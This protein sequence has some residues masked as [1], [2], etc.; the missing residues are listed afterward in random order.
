MAKTP[1]FISLS[2]AQLDIFESI[3]TALGSTNLLLKEQHATVSS[4]ARLGGMKD[5][6]IKKIRQIWE[7]EMS[8]LGGSIGS[9]LGGARADAD[10]TG[11]YI[12][13]Q[14]AGASKSVQ[15]LLGDLKK[16][17]V[18][19]VEFAD[20]V[21]KAAQETEFVYKNAA[22]IFGFMGDDAE[23]SM[24][25]VNQQAG[26]YMGTMEGLAKQLQFTDDQYKI[27]GLSLEVFAGKGGKGLRK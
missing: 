6:E 25:R 27:N 20:Q 7:D 15:G 24:G 3:N 2:S 10:Y 8:K 22:K 21:G 14:S 26:Q 23:S 9:S 17:R 13:G 12:R 18:A 19:S 4:I 16:A 5:S 11:D 1:T